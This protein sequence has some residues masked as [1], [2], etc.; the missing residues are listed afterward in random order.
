MVKTLPFASVVDKVWSQAPTLEEFVAG[1][2]PK[3]IKAKTWR[4]IAKR[5][6][7]SPL[8]GVIRV[9]ELDVPDSGKR[10]RQTICLERGNAYRVFRFWTNKSLASKYRVILSGRVHGS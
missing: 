2:K 8:N 3:R 1:E 9:L 6:K 10:L 4:A 7:D 5:A